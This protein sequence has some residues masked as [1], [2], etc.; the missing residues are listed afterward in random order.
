MAGINEREDFPKS[1]GIRL[2]VLPFVFFELV[3]FVGAV[4]YLVRVSL[5]EPAPSAAFTEGTWTVS[6]YVDVLADGY[7]LGRLGYS[8]SLGT[9]VTA[10]T[11][12]VGFLY[13]Y[14]AWRARGITKVTLL[15]SV[16]VSLLL[17]IV[18]KVYAWVILLSTDG[19]FNRILTVTVIEEPVTL[20]GNDFA[21]VVG[22]VYSMLPYVVLTIYS[23]LV[24]VDERALEAA[25]DLGAGRVRS[26]R[27]V[28]VPEAVPGIAAAAVI[29]FSWSS[30][31]Y[32]APVFLGSPSER[33][34][35]VETGRILIDNFDWAKAAAL[36]VVSVVSV[37]TVVATVFLIWSVWRRF[38][39]LSSGEVR[40]MNGVR[41]WIWKPTVLPD[42]LLPTA[43]GLCCAA[44]FSFLTLPIAVVVA[45]SLSG[46]T[47]AAFPPES[48]SLR[49]Y[50]GFV[51]DGDWL[52]SFGNSL[53]ISAGTA[54]AAVSLGA[55]A[56]YGLRGL[57]DGSR[58]AVVLF[59]V[60]PL[61]TPLIVVAVSLVVLMG[62]FNA[63]GSYGAVVVGHTVITAPLALLITYGALSRV[64]WSTREAAIDLGATPVRAF[65]EAT[66]PQ[67]RSAVVASAF[68]ACVLSMHEFL[69]ALFIT[70][71]TTRTVPVLTWI[72]LRNR[73]DPTASVVSTVLVVGM[74][75][76]VSIAAA[77]V[78][79][80][81]LA[82]EL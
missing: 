34:V 1:P 26:V 71:F 27:E 43:F 28:V 39:G 78:G 76:G 9:V 82:R 52:S 69:V 58:K 54:V 46:S 19:A 37:L 29:C 55:T 10:V 68:V 41:G 24:T 44:V 15:S 20:V 65:R 17:S 3:F 30:V 18:I 2:V 61:A 72:T 16:V 57:K 49:W 11:V 23:V 63:V 6:N 36:G 31:A 79:I 14:A 64:D 12:P 38:R 77:A 5:A 32:A 60:I 25:R 75:V 53:L 74:V 47:P 56:A 7:L 67:M 51:S 13:A 45:T 22:L 4:A 8:L 59:A 33:T 62:R 42:R 35:A 70:D 48:L 73:L 50:T 66:L 81:R 21:V 40:R 80:D